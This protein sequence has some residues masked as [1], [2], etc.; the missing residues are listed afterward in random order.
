MSPTLPFD[1]IALIIDIV[2]ANNDTDLLKE[3]ALVSYSFHQICSKHLFASVELHEIDRDYRLAPSMKGFVKLLKSRPNVVKYIRKLTYYMYSVDFLKRPLLPSHPRLDNKHLF[4]SVLPNLCRTISHLHC[5]KITS[6]SS[7]YGVHWNTQ[8]S[9]LAS[10]FLHLMHLPTINH[11]DLSCIRGFPLSSFTP[12]VNLHRL[13][14]L[15]LG[16]SEEKD[17]LE[18]VI[19]SE[20]MPRIREFHTLVCSSLTTALLHAKN[21]D[22]Q[23][24]FDLTDLRR[25][26]IGL[27]DEP[28]IRYLLQ[29][30]ELLEKLHLS[31]QPGAPSAAGL[32]DNLSLGARTLKTLDISV[33]IFNCYGLVPLA[34][35]WEGLEAMAGHNILESC[36]ET[37]FL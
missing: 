15:F 9:P 6:E 16:L 7:E 20:T 36:V 34:G 35:L 11:I 24:A 31:F 32:Y 17:F 30:A 14:T 4:S 37:G 10:A 26:S 25:L 18:I 23:P 12:S 8:G 21:Q 22:G 27:D 5:L 19:P 13:D 2:G 28:I 3:L 33:S 29:N 1:I